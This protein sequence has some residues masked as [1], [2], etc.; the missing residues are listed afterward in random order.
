M[1]FTLQG[2]WGERTKDNATDKLKSEYLV[3][4]VGDLADITALCAPGSLAHTA[5]YALMWELANDGT[6]WTAV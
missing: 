1:A 4:A 6:T 3:D 2:E 5:G